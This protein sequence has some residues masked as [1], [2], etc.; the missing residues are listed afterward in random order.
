MPDIRVMKCEHCGGDKYP[1]TYCCD[2]GYYDAAWGNL[3]AALGG[4]V[5][6]LLFTGIIFGIFEGIC[7]CLI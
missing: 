2:K 6:A 5:I 4:L 3:R 7:Q 1:E